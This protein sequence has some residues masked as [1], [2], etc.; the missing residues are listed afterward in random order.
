MRIT[1]IHEE[2]QSEKT[3]LQLLWVKRRKLFI[4]LTIGYK[5]VIRRKTAKKIQI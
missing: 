3:Y 1:G 5:R 4:L 2:I